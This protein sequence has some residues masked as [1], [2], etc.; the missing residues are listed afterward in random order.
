M[1]GPFF[2][3]RDVWQNRKVPDCGAVLREV[4]SYSLGM[5][6]RLSGRVNV[7]RS[8]VYKSGSSLKDVFHGF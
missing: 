4:E 5:G 1:R 2:G 6:I 7:I 3:E 8:I